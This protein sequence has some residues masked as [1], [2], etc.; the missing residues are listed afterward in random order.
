MANFCALC[1]EE[2]YGF[3]YKMVDTG[4]NNKYTVCT[5]CGNLLD[6]INERHEIE[7]ISA[8]AEE[9]EA[10]IKYDS[11]D[12]RLKNY[13]GVL[14]NSNGKS[15]AEVKQELENEVQAPDKTEIEDIWGHDSEYRKKGLICRIEGVRGRRMALYPNKCEI[16]TDV[17]LGSVITSN[18]TDGSKTIFF[19]DCTGVQFKKA[20]LTIGY[21][22]IEAPGV[23]MNN[24]ASNFFSE[25]TFTFE[26]N[27]V[28][29]VTNEFMDQ[30]YEYVQMRVEGYKYNDDALLNAELP[31]LLAQMHEKQLNTF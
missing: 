11:I 21:L 16:I 13:V 14:M 4:D 23:Q 19:K 20:K 2:V 7:D 10:R 12:Q 1:K 15:S 8:M 18:A 17:T 3:D 6:Q 28:T 9:L 31:P 27:N 24:V 22:Q 30:V 26:L 29:G 25:N 5:K